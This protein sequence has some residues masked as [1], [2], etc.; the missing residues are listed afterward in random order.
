ML[1]ANYTPSGYDPQGAFLPDR[2]DWIVAPISR[3]RDTADALTIANWKAQLTLLGGESETV[4]LHRFGHWA[5]GWFEIVLVHPSRS[6][7]ID[8]LVGGLNADG[9]LDEKLLWEVEDAQESEA[10]NSW[11]KDEFWKRLLVALPAEVRDRLDSLKPEHQSAAIDKAFDFCMQSSD[12]WIE[13]HNDG[14]HFNFDL[15]NRFDEDEIAEI[16]NAALKPNGDNS[17][18]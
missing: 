12:W 14:P 5:C 1:Y 15:V 13:H 11:G 6:D 3:T 2:Q 17:N 4:E 7:D 10:W 8:D 9:V 16:L 18:A